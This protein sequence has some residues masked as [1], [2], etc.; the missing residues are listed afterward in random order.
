V[1]SPDVDDM[2]KLKRLVCYLRYTKD[3]CLTLETDW[4]QIVKWWVDTSFAVHQDM[5]SHPG[6]AMSLAKGAIYSASTR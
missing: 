5:H 3:L 6:G 2:K 4:L 1:K